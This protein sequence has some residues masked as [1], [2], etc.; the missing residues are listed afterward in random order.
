MKFWWEEFSFLQLLWRSDKI[1]FVETSS[2][3]TSSLSSRFFLPWFPPSGEN[4]EHLQIKY[5]GQ[6][7]LQT[8]VFPWNTDRY[9]YF[10]GLKYLCQ[11]GIFLF[12]YLFTHIFFTI[13]RYNILSQINVTLLLKRVLQ[14]QFSNKLWKF[15]WSPSKFLAPAQ[16]PSNKQS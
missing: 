2:G 7:I 3:G 10:F 13:W 16:V 5:P 9:I 4:Q 14:L 8:F 11:T 15:V 6:D 1:S 12:F